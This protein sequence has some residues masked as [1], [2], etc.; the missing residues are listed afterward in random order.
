MY[1]ICTLADLRCLRDVRAVPAGLVDCLE[2][3]LQAM[4]RRIG[5]DIAI[6]AFSLDDAGE[7]VVILQPGDGPGV[8]TVL[9]IAEVEPVFREALTLQDAHGVEVAYQEV[10]FTTAHRQVRLYLP[11]GRKEEDD[12]HPAV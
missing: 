3:D 11:S 1:V 2:I 8:Y 5:G 6:D 12:G 9:G 4:Y 7:L 10:E